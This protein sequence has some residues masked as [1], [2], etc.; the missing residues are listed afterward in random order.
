MLQVKQSIF[1]AI[2]HNKIYGISRIC[3]E[4]IEIADH[5][6]QAISI[7]DASNAE[8]KV[9]KVSE[10]KRIH[11]ELAKLFGKYEIQ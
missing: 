9:S 7:V 5:I 3:K 8:N 11:A 4:V 1:R 10:L 6:N 2:E